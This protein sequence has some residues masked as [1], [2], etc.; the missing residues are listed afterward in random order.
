MKISKKKKDINIENIKR[1]KKSSK[2][3]IENTRKIGRERRGSR[4]LG[5]LQKYLR[6]M[7]RNSR[8]ST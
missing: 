4:F 7:Y 8:K 6:G 2:I 1:S 5:N 3:S